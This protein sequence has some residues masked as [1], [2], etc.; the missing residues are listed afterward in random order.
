MVALFGDEI[1]FRSDFVRID[2]RRSGGAR[3]GS[4]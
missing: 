3:A 2:M 1:D 4:R